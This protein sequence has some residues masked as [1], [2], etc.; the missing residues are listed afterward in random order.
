M[1]FRRNQSV[2]VIKQRNSTKKQLT[3]EVTETLQREDWRT[4]RPAQQGRLAP[5]SALAQGHCGVL[6]NPCSPYAQPP[7]N[8]LTP[9]TASPEK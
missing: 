8:R 7:R 4:E 1:N 6:P 2:V 5:D 3:L 9:I